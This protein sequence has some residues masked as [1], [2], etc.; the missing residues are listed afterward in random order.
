V[1][2]HPNHTHLYGCFPQRA[3]AVLLGAGVQGDGNVGAIAKDIFHQVG[4]NPLRPKLYEAMTAS[5]VDIFNFLLE[6]HR[7]S[8]VGFQ[9]FLNRLGVFGIRLTCNVGEYR[10]FWL[11]ELD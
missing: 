5:S 6:Q 3:I 10:D 2:L 4:E 7:V 1:Q 9:D 8:Q 11:V